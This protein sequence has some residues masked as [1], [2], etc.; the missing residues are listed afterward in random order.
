M[1]KTSVS[2]HPSA[3]SHNS[4]KNTLKMAMGLLESGLNSIGQEI[5][6]FLIDSRYGKK[7]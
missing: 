6:R 2:K 5:T 7:R 1:V 3:S 4:N